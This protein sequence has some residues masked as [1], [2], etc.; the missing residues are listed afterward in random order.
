MLKRKLAKFKW[1]LTD[2]RSR[3][4]RNQVPKHAGYVQHA[5]RDYQVYPKGGNL[6]QEFFTQP[7]E[8]YP[9]IIDKTTPITSIGSCFAVEIRHHLK[10]AEFNFINTQNSWSGSDEWGRVY[11]TKNLLQIFQY[12]FAEFLPNLR[13]TQSSRGYYDPYREG[14]FF[15]TEEAAEEELLKHR[16]D[17]R[18]ALTECRVLIVTPGQNEAWI[19]QTDGLA[20]VHRPPVEIR[21]ALGEER[22]AI[23]QFSLEEN[24]DYLNGSL[25]LLWVNNPETMVVFTLSPV[26]SDA[27]FYDTNVAVRSIEN[28][29]ILLLAIKTV[30]AQHPDRA[31]YFPSFEMTML[32]HNV[33]LQLDNRHVRP[34][35]VERIMATFDQRFVSGD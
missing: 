11:T 23:K 16:Q 1:K 7:S 33:N 6:S 25:E 32:S 17:S 31:Y 24:I 13:I 20:W 3:I 22:F 34:N 21:K 18:Q 29:A 8:R 35:V 10:D 30:V 15:S 14:R 26:P 27:T 12:T 19:D 4:F 28:K 5:L 2:L 9:K